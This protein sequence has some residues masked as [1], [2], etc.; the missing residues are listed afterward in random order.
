MTIIKILPLSLLMLIAVP[1]LFAQSATVT[2]TT[3]HQTMDGFGGEDVNLNASGCSGNQGNCVFGFTSGQA[4][5]FFSTSS[6]IGLQ[7][8]RYANNGCPLTGACTPSSTTITS[9]AVSDLQLAVANGAIVELTLSPPAN[10]KYSGNLITNT[11]GADGGCMDTSQFT[12]YANYVVSWI[13]YIQAQNIPVSTISA[14]NEPNGAGTTTRCTM[15]AS[16]LDTFIKTY[17]GPAMSTAGLTTRLMLSEDSASSAQLFSTCLADSGCAQYVS[18]VSFHGYGSGSQDGMGTGYCCRTA[19]SPPANTSGK[20]IWQSEV[21]GGFTFPGTA[22][23]LWSWDASMADAL[24]WARSIHDYLT[25]TGAS[26]WEYWDLADCCSSNVGAPYNDGLMQGNLST[27]SQRYYVVGNWSK[28]MRPGWV[29]IDATANPTS[30][31]YVTAFKDPSSD[32]FAIVAINQNSFAVTVDFSLSGFPSVAS[33]TPTVTSASV[34]LTDQTDVTVTGAA[35]SDSLPATSV[36]TFHP[37]SS[38]S[39]KIPA[40]PTGLTLTIR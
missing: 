21:N 17:L 36:V 12:A 28:F 27:V 6:G 38:S 40:P 32:N 37:T 20:R 13:Q 7:I 1:S 18:I 35:F 5:S 23:G 26:G 9:A 15:T 3:T 34:N 30:G 22:T 39:S 4:A 2:W 29:R 25:I 33:V 14:F 10:L 19:I 31:V 8:I 11:V 16:L 24:V